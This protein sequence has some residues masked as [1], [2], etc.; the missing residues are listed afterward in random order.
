ELAKSNAQLVERMVRIIQELEMDV[1]T[2]EEAR[3]MIGLKP[4]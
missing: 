4:L 2:P 1:A 3:Q